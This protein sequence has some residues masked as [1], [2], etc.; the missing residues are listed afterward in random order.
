MPVLTD[1]RARD[2]MG[3]NDKLTLNARRVLHFG[4]AEKGKTLRIVPVLLIH[5]EAGS[6]W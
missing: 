5:A 6:V 2:I 1:N 4:L 3:A